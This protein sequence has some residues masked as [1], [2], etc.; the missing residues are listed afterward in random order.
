MFTHGV[1]VSMLRCWHGWPFAKV[2]LTFDNDPT[3][4]VKSVLCVHCNTEHIG[5]SWFAEC[6]YDNDKGVYKNT[7]ILRDGAHCV[8]CNDCYVQLCVY[9][10]ILFKVDYLADFAKK[11][12]YGDKSDSSDYASDDEQQT[13]ASDDEQQTLAY[14]DEQSD[15]DE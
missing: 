8:L 9:R 10:D 5:T 11:V 15:S 3:G 7:D 12:Y 4:S 6:C 13:L 14:D 1:F 2:L